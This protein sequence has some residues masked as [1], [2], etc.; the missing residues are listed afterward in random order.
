[1]TSLRRFSETAPGELSNV[2]QLMPVVYHELRALAGAYFQAESFP[3]TLQPTALVHEAYLRLARYGQ[4]NWQGRIHFLASAACAMR[5][6]LVDHARRKRRSKRWGSYLRVELGEGPVSFG[7]R[8]E[9]LLALDQALNKLAR[10]DSRKAHIVELRYF[11][12]LTVEEVAELLGVSKSTVEQEW[13]FIRAWLRREF[14]QA[15]A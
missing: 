13:T 12:G 15:R 14:S 2:N 9:D 4:P 10:K 1:M 3:H 7:Q 6:I 8:P 5:Q 11:G